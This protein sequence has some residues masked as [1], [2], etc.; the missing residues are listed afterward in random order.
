MSMETTG[1]RQ[2]I[3]GVSAAIAAAS[4]GSLPVAAQGT[5]TEFRPTRHAE[6]AWLDERAGTHRIFIDSATPAGAG[7]AILY[8][9]NLFG[10]HERA[11]AGGK[12]ADLAMVV[13]LRH[14][15]TPFAFTNAVWAKY[16]KVLS[17]LTG[18]TDPKT[19][20][21]PLTNLYT[22][23]DYGLLLP[24]LGQTIEKVTKLGAYFAV[25]DGAT[26]FLATNLAGPMASTPE[27]IYKDL[28]SNMIPNSRLVHR[29]VLAAT[30]SQEYGYSLLY[31]G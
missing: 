23:G 2:M 28:T 9:N 17:A 6:D 16:G 11:Y 14:F 18:F 30:R 4:V 20:E 31:A 3:S 21:A 15:A 12:M 1:R 10:G 26:N 7:N 25:C 19:K 5:H 13:C 22:S 24:T 29:G 8:A 27:A